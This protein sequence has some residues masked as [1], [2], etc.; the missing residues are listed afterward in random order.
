VLLR[1]R[2]RVMASKKAGIFKLA[3]VLRIRYCARKKA[4]AQAQ[5]IWLG[6]RSSSSPRRRSDC[7]GRSQATTAM[8]QL[9]HMYPR[10]SEFTIESTGPPRSRRTTIAASAAIAHQ[11]AAAA[12]SEAVTLQERLTPEKARNMSAQRKDGQ[13]SGE[14]MADGVLPSDSMTA[15]TSKR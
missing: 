4:K 3:L 5:P 1:L 6:P 13:R 7:A 9:P 11:K 12:E 15:R 8:A 10:M 2:S 14:P